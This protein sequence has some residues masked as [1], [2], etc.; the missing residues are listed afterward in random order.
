MRADQ[1]TIKKDYAPWRIRV[2]LDQRDGFTEQKRKTHYDVL[3]TPD[4]HPTPSSLE[5]KR[6]GTRAINAG[7]FKQ[8]DLLR[9]CIEE[10]AISALLLSGII[11]DYCT[12]EVPHGMSIASRLSICLQRTREQY[13]TP[14]SPQRSL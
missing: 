12:E 13:S 8:A 11:V 3:S 2:A 9:E 6:D 5:L 4:S 1:N 14:A 7:P 10:A